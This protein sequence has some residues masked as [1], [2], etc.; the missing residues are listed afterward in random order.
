[1]PEWWPWGRSKRPD[2]E[3]AAPATTRPEPAWHRLPAVEPMVG[4]IEPTVHLQG[5]T[6]SLTTSQNPGITGSLELLSTGHADRFSVL[7]VA[8]H[9]S[10]APARPTNARVAPTP[11]SRTWAP[12]PIA[13]QRALRS[14]ATVQGADEITPVREMHSVEA[15]S[16]TVGPLHSMVQAPPPDDRRIL[17]VADEQ[18]VEADEPQSVRAD[19]PE[20]A[21]I[22][23]PSSTVTED[24]V[25]Q[26]AQPAPSPA[27]APPAVQRLSLSA[28]PVPALA[29]Q[30][31]SAS[32]L[33]S[34]DTGLTPPPRHLPSLQRAATGSDA[35]PQWFNAGRPIP[36]LRSID[37]PGS[38]PAPR[39]PDTATP[40]TVGD[41]GNA[42]QRWI[43]P[44][45]TRAATPLPPDPAPPSTPSESDGQLPV[46]RTAE[47]QQS[48]TAPPPVTAQRAMTNTAERDPTPRTE[49]SPTPDVV[50]QSLPEITGQSRPAAEV[51]RL[52][53]VEAR[54]A[55]TVAG[56]EPERRT[57]TIPTVQRA[58]S[59]VSANPLPEQSP[60]VVPAAHV[61]AGETPGRSDSWPHLQR[62]GESET[63]RI[64]Q[65][66]P[67]AAEHATPTTPQSGVIQR[68]ASPVVEPASALRRTGSPVTPSHSDST[69]SP[70]V[71]RAAAAGRRLVVLPPLRPSVTNAHDGP[72]SAQ[73]PPERSVLFESPRPVGL[74]RMFG[75]NGIRTDRG[76]GFRPASS[77]SAG[78][79]S[80]AFSPGESSSDPASGV[81]QFET[82]GPSYDPS[83]NTV[84]FAS[85]TVQREP[86]A[87]P[88]PESPPAAPQAPGT[89]SGPAP[90]GPAAASPA[91]GG[92]V[93]ELVNKLYDPLAARLRAE[94]WLDR[95]RAGVLMD[96]GR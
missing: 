89:P 23:H 7:D 1:M 46:V 80:A 77:G 90:S 29:S 58:P 20:P 65:A 51:Q 28:D 68:V 69:V 45:T 10:G 39:K 47:T 88:P 13:V 16:D 34:A 5:F 38:Q 96:L 72:D 57:P 92:D 78:F 12:S 85:S 15:T 71:Q 32:S 49:N 22:D 84:T 44:G 50:V 4:G 95:E 14:T 60:H 6:E 76:V 93:E 64:L 94:L 26:A 81:P 62:A 41:S 43:D 35:A 2:P 19:T 30:A 31:V 40:K 73:S 17:G 70:V 36:V 9:S 67:H 63:T 42:V 59:V 56:A 27:S 11:Q 66:L 61:E 82:S 21:S 74:Q 86:E 75:D 55:A 25:S 83:T 37:A 18:E 87:A 79:A 53:M 33:G 54:P 8:H 48:T 3:L 91:G 24:L 52:P